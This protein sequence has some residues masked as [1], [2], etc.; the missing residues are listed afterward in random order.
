MN[1]QD[2]RLSDSNAFEDCGT[3]LRDLYLFNICLGKEQV[4]LGKEKSL[5]FELY[6]EVY[7]QLYSKKDTGRGNII[8][9]PNEEMRYKPDCR[10][11]VRFLNG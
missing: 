1:H 2:D 4:A 3:L 5:C 9:L 10:Y 7:V 6:E 8:G 11:K